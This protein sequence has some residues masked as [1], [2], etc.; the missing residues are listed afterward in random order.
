M[1]VV[2]RFDAA[3]APDASTFLFHPDQTVDEQ[4]DGTVTVSFEV[5]GLV[6]SC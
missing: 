6:E 3:A 1:R 5:G 4:D 2:L